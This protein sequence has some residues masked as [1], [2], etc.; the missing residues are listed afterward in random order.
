MNSNRRKENEATSLRVRA[1]VS[2][3]SWN[4]FQDLASL[5]TLR[6]RKPLSAVNTDPEFLSLSFSLTRTSDIMISMKLEITMTAS[7]MLNQ[8]PLKYILKPI[9]ISLSSISTAK[10]HAKRRFNFSRIL[11]RLLSYGY[12][13]RER[14][15]VLMT[16]DKTINVLKMKLSWIM[17]A[18][19]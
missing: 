15:T 6:S 7:K 12:L 19:L 4:L 16:I 10:M 1:I 17:Y 8:S 13:S 5:K 9:E 18:I 11:F 3:R 14:T 2:S